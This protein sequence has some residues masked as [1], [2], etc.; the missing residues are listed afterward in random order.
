MKG[1]ECASN[2]L[3]VEVSVLYYIIITSPTV[4]G[5]MDGDAKTVLYGR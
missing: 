5:G 3:L 1:V 2:E 4:Q